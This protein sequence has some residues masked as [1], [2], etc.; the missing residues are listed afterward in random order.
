[1]DTVELK[2]YGVFRGTHCGSVGVYTHEDGHT[3]AGGHE[4]TVAHGEGVVTY[5][6]GTTYSGQLAD[7]RWHGHREEHH[8]HGGVGY[9]L[10]ERGSVVHG[11]CVEA[12]GACEYDGER[13]G[14]DHAG[15]AALKDAAQQAGVRMPPTRIQRNGRTVHDRVCV[16]VCESVCARLCALRLGVRERVYVCEFVA[17][18]MRVRASA[19]V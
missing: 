13:C 3:Y 15:F 12:D 10:Y 11:A 16:G 18:G 17:L 6:P 8:A 9:I 5:S 1:M 7:G 14:T 19:C 4:G 2:G